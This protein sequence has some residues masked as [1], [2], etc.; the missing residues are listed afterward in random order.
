MQAPPCCKPLF[1]L[2][3][4]HIH[5]ADAP[6]AFGRTRRL[7]GLVLGHQVVDQRV[8]VGDTTV[9]MLRPFAEQAE[10]IAPSAR[11]ALETTR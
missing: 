5:T 9:A 1:P 3:D 7:A 11:K 2:A 4:R 10:A 8:Q 6:R